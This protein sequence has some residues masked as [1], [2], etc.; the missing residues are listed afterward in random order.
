MY[1]IYLQKIYTNAI[2]LSKFEKMKASF[3]RSELIIIEQ[4]QCNIQ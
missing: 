1:F 2:I 3:P 4:I